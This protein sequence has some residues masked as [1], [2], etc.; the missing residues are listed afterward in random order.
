MV[1][2]GK[3]IAG[4]DCSHEIKRHLLLGRKAMTNVDSILKSRDI[5]LLTKVHI[6]KAM[7]FPVVMYGCES[8]TIMKAEH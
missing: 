3:I 7:V 5:T 2:P 8:W 6:V 1:R 4:G